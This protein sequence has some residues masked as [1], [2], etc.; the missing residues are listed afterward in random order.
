M[1]YLNFFL[2]IFALFISMNCDMCDSGGGTKPPS[3]DQQIAQLLTDG[4]LKFTKAEYD[5]AE[6]Y[7]NEAL[8]LNSDIKEAFAGKAWSK[9]M[10]D[11]ADF[12]SI[13]ELFKE[14]QSDTSIVKDVKAGLAI[15]SNLQKKYSASINY[16]DELLAS[17]ASYVFQHKTDIDYHD[18][19][20][21]EAHSYFYSKNFDKA[22][23]TILKLTT[24]YIFDPEDSS[25]W[26]VEGDKY[27]S[28]EGAISA[29]LAKLS[30]QYKSF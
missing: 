4:W 17:S 26:V 16:I 27:P 23:E 22:Y 19:L 11:K 25:T 15:V 29:L 18:L 1:R 6:Y 7:F 5:S 3:I 13:E 2:M 12:E 30:S 28:Y 24:N 20:V 21:I 9:L 8:K 10:L 14:A